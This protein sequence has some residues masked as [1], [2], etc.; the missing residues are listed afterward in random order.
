[1]NKFIP[2]DFKDDKETCQEV[3]QEVKNL[4]KE[5]WA[6]KDESIL[7]D[8]MIIWLFGRKLKRKRALK[9]AIRKLGRIKYNK[10]VKRG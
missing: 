6:I 2:H 5:F 10:Q 8:T 7:P 9:K 4:I 3:V 1:M